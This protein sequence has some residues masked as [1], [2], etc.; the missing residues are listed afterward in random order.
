MAGDVLSNSSLPVILPEWVGIPDNVRAFSTTRV[1]GCS[2]GVFGDADGLAHGLNLGAHV[3]DDACSVAQNRQ[4]LEQLLPASVKWLNQV[5]GAHVLDAAQVNCESDADAALVAAPN[6]ICAVLTADCLPVLFTDARGS[7]VA[8]AHA[9]WRGLAGGVLQNTIAMM[10]ARGAEE[11]LA[12][13]GPAIGAQQFEVGAEVR[14]IFIEKNPEATKCFCPHPRNS[15]KFFADIY[16]LA[17]MA[18]S[19]LGGV[20]ISG[21]KHCTVSESATFYSYRRDGQTGRMAS[22]I[23]L[24]Q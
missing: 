7:V 22:L 10:R 18:M 13:M 16:G 2:R 17:Q 21:G 6:V 9:G 1:G 24:T 23:W 15:G 3:G 4:R 14:E 20:Q 12:W 8:A 5:H 19:A 11:I